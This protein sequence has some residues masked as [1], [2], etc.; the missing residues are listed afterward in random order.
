MPSDV[1]ITNSSNP[2]ASWKMDHV[3]IL[4][5]D[6]EAATAWYKE[7][8]GWEVTRRFPIGGKTYG[9]VRSADGGLSFEFMGGPGPEARPEYIDLG[10]SQSL[11]GLHHVCFRV[12]NVDAAITA[13]KE[14]GVRIV[15]EPRDVPPISSRF[16]FFADPWDNLFEVIQAISL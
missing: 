7:T 11:S 14:R 16:A 3:G 6:F 5:P 12:E 9:F 2:F 8:L 1:S 15:N 4:L 13:L 10:S